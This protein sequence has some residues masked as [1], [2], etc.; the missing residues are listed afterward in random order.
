[1]TTEAFR[2][3][4]EPFR[5]HS[6]EP[7]RLTTSEQRRDAVRDAGYNLFQVRAEDVLIDLLTDSGTGAMS[8]DQWAAIQ[9][10]DESYAGSPSYYRFRDAVRELFPF[11]HVIP[12][13]QG[14]A[15][16]KIL[17]GLL[18]GPGLVVPNNTHFDTT[19]ANVEA[20]G[21]TAVD[22][23]IPEGRDPQSLHPFKGNMDVE[24]LEA[25]LAERADDVPVVFVTITNNSG[26]GQP[27]SLA[28][29]RAVREVCDRYAKKLFLDACRF[30]ENA[31]FIRERE[32]GQQGRDVVDIVRDIAALADGMTM[33]AK[34]DP[35]GNIGGW[36]AM[37]DDDL[38]TRCRNV[39]IL[40]EG[41]PTYGGLAGRDLEAL[42]QGL[43][44]VVDHDYLRYRIA[45]T[46]YLG[47][48][49][50]KVGMPVL[51]PTGGHAVYLDAR[52]LLTHLDPLQYPG[53]SLAV[54]LYE[55]G[56]VRSC[57][58][59]TVMFG[60][61]PDGT[62]APASMDLVRLAIPRRTYTQSHI[63][64]VIEVCEEVAA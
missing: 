55:V 59:G 46:S 51:S 43:T 52:A 27:V 32:P 29:L 8:R 64:Y 33:S 47:E 50:R 1:M 37:D 34:K 56:G 7:L 17:F 20:T 12:T 42:A 31:W 19:R 36:L 63:D 22:L 60:R 49:L 38:A 25:L 23:L 61:Q 4:I 26:G 10:G 48:A 2:T 13:H 9:H 11:E 39:L 45:S 35:M 3:I 28:N 24:A 40:T 6:V 16:E 57:E 54:A 44:E 62:E 30:A 41:F 58:I 21:A 14:R 15:A 18:G 53:Q 5:I